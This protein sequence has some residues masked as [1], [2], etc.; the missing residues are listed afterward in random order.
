MIKL[1]LGGVRATDYHSRESY[2][3]TRSNI[4]FCGED[5]KVIVFTSSVPN[6]GKSST[7]LNIAL[8][9]AESGQKVLYIDADLRKSVLQRRT[10][11]SQ[12][13]RGLSHYLV[14][15][16]E[17]K[18]IMHDVGIPRIRVVFPGPKPP[19]PAELLGHERF[20]TMITACRHVF[21]YIIIDSPPL[22]SVIDSAVIAK[23][24]DG[25]IYVVAAKTIRYKFAQQII[26]Q[27]NR[28]GCPVLGVILSKVKMDENPFGSYYGYYG[29]HYE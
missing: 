11:V 21:D 5:K 10:Q 8:S 29:H 23:N 7:S 1:H 19:N 26:K 14:G 3:M 28:T 16:A 13:I 20:E 22:G 2:K 18:D 9:L 12:Q 6:E 27:I 4:Q 17:F 24:C 25:L 15:Q